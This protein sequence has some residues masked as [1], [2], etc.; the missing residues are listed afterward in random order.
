[1]DLEQP[2]LLYRLYLV[3]DDDVLLINLRTGRALASDS[4]LLLVYVRPELC[5]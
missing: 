2:L 3:G 1:M 4:A 5:S